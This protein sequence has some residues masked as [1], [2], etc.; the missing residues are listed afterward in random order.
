MC[1]KCKYCGKEFETG[2]K[3]GGHVSKCPMN[4]NKNQEK[5]HQIIKE[6]FEKRNP[7]EEHK[8]KCQVCGKEYILQI[9]HKQFK[10]GEY[11]KTCCSQCAHK[12]TSLNTNLE[13]KNKKICKSL[14]GKKPP[15]TGKKYINGQWV[16]NPNW[17]PYNICGYCGKHFIN[18]RSK[19]CCDECKKLGTHINLSNAIKGKT[20]GI[21]PNTYKKYKSGLYHGIHCD[22]SWE[23]AFVIYCEEHN[24]KLIRNT[25]PL[26]YIFENKEFKY[27]PDF[28]I[29]NKLYEIKGYENERA[30]EKH[31]QH[32]EVIYLDKKKMKPYIEYV[33]DKYGKDFIKLYDR[34][35]RIPE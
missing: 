31:K 35:D 22:S 19:Y 33:I 15:I 34:L 27:Y 13:E 10:Q 11:K 9:R 6:N 24:I 30:I 12:L 5:I 17:K 1:H 21:R 25:L 32:P 8:L 28:I 26:T 18:R 3:L 23:L 4:P 7:L 16:E 20:G 29:D 14:V 2:V